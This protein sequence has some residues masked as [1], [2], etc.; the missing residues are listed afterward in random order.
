M[1]PSN[2][3][4]LCHPI[5][6][7]PSI[8]PSIRVFFNVSELTSGA[9]STGA[10]TSTSVLP[11]NIQGWFLLGLTGLIDLLAK[12]LS[13]AF[14]SIKFW[15]HL[16]ISLVLSLLYGPTLISVHGYWKNHSFDYT[17]VLWRPTRSSRTNTKKAVLFIIGDWIAKVGSQET[18]GVTGKFD[19]WVQNEAGERSIEFCQENALVIANAFFQQ[20]KR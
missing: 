15:K 11:M 14:S 16:I 2:H 20:Y 9:Q 3:L 1:M 10:S 17:M 13:R 4:T 19:L 7:M 12:G 18:S 6:L 5:F 8:F